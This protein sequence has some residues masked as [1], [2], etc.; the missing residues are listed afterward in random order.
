M[1]K[2]F[3]K[4][5]QKLSKKEVNEKPV[6]AKK[7]ESSVSSDSSSEDE[8]TAKKVTANP[9]T[10]QEAT[11]IVEQCLNPAKSAPVAYQNQ[12]LLYSSYSSTIDDKI[13]KKSIASINQE[14]SYLEFNLDRRV[15]S[16]KESRQLEINLECFSSEESF[17][18]KLI[19]FNSK[20]FE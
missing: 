8:I 12:E 13:A 4:K 5:Q 17:K 18:E 1:G 16:I 3:Q 20:Q 10:K 6:T 11:T 19:F 2:S 14:I 15:I 9:G 7:Q